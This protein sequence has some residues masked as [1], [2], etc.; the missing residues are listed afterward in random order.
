[1]LAH[2]L[3]LVLSQVIGPART[4]DARERTFRYFEGGEE[5]MERARLVL[6]MCDRAVIRTL[7]SELMSIPLRTPPNRAAATGCTPAF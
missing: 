1:M 4:E 3:D 5:K 2:A 6:D 7:R